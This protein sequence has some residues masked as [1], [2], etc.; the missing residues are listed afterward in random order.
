[1]GSRRVPPRPNSLP[2]PSCLGRERVQGG[3][4]CPRPLPAALGGCECKCLW[5]EASLRPQSWHVLG[6]RGTWWDECHA[7]SAGVEAPGCSGGVGEVEVSHCVSGRG[8]MVRPL[9]RARAVVE[10][11][12]VRTRGMANKAAVVVGVCSRRP[13]QAAS[14]AEFFHRP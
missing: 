4:G 9:R 14:A 1:M 5:L 12:W 11:L 6:I 3:L 10:S 7:G 8:G 2:S 13:S